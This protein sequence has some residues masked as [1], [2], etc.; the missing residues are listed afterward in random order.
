MHLKKLL[1]S[2]SKFYTLWLDNTCDFPPFSPFRY[3]DFYKD[4]INRLCPIS[5]R[6]FWR[7]NSAFFIKMVS[8]FCGESYMTYFWVV[9]V[10][11]G[12]SGFRKYKCADAPLLTCGRDFLHR[13]F[14]FFAALSTSWKS[15]ILQF[16]TRNV[17]EY[18]A[19][20]FVSFFAWIWLD[21]C[22]SV[23]DLDTSPSTHGW[24]Q[25]ASCLFSKLNFFMVNLY[26][27]S[28]RSLLISLISYGR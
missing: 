13:Y 26:S 7:N 2:Q 4:F 28:L 11:A 27:K 9:A 15:K 14:E 21:Q 5:P 17:G 22:F 23:R 1:S 18:P 6:C 10:S 12:Q 25:W 3:I 16:C 8:H 20:I 19:W 24:L